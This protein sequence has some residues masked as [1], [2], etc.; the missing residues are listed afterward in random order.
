MINIEIKSSNQT[1]LFGHD[2]LF[3]DIIDLYKNNKLPNKILFSGSKGVG[4]AT[5]AYHLVNYI[6][7]KDELLNYDLIN[8]KINDLNKS[9]KHVL[10]NAHPNFYLIDLLDEKK[11]IEISQIRKMINYTNKSAFNNKERIILIDNAEYLNPSSSNALLKIVEEPNDNIIFIFIYD[12]S[13]KIL[14]TVKSR[15]LKFNFS[16]TSRETLDIT[17][18]ILDEDINT[19]ISEDFISYYNSIGDLINL[20]KFSSSNKIDISKTNLKSFLLNVFENKLYKKDPYI[21][22][23]VFKLVELYLLKLL[24][25]NKSNKKI[26]DIYHELI[27][28]IDSIKKFNL[29]EESIFIEMKTKLLDG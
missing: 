14:D 25:L 27:N 21:K 28:K 12:S 23:N 7:S 10:N 29:D 2:K 22:N 3:L 15:C 8:F 5:F 6:L 13:K 19:L 16:L 24:N 26:F 17:N 9:F 11:V 20:I 4:K 1:K 18:K